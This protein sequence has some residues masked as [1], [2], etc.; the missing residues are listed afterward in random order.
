MII[1]NA[2][3]LLLAH[4]RNVSFARQLCSEVKT[5]K[6]QTEK[7]DLYSGVLLE[8]LPII[9]KP[10]DEVQTKVQVRIFALFH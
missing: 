7:W 6:G 2:G 9:G 4:F 1:R 10:L 3:Q 8:R 5:A